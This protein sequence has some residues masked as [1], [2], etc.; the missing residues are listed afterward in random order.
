MM[1]VFVN[2]ISHFEHFSKRLVDD[3]FK[4]RV[5]TLQDILAFMTDS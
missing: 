4:L 1:R 5:P 3:F 2:Y